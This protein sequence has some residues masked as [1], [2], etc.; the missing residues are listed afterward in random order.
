MTKEEHTSSTLAAEDSN[1][2]QIFGVVSVGKDRLTVGLFGMICAQSPEL[3]SI[4]TSCF[5][6]PTMQCFVS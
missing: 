5:S 6:L 2:Y 4:L 3:N 1:I